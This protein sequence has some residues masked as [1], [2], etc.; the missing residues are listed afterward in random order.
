MK[1]H[2]LK[3]ELNIFSLHRKYR[4]A[5]VFVIFE[6][7]DLHHISTCIFNNG[8]PLNYHVLRTAT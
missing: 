8:G 5:I 6:S 2:K 4:F 7:L 3:F 1:T